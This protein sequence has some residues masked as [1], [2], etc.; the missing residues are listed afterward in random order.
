MHPFSHC[1][2]WVI[3]AAVVVSMVG[4]PAISSGGT[5]PQSGGAQLRR[6]SV[7]RSGLNPII[8]EKRNQYPDPGLVGDARQV[9]ESILK[10]VDYGFS[11]GV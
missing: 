10:H 3:L 7:V 9:I 5:A 6:R 4:L 8:F 11:E 2:N 1:K